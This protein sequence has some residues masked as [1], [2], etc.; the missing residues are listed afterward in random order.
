MREN[1]FRKNCEVYSPGKLFLQ[2]C[3]VL[4]RVIYSLDNTQA[5]SRRQ[6]E[7]PEDEA[8][9]FLHVVEGHPRRVQRRE[10]AVA[11]RLSPSTVE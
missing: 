5:A 7:K 10:E 3:P 9:A 2:G 4:A 6:F 11:R 8:K 1:T